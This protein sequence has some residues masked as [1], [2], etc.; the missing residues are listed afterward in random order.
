IDE[1]LEMAMLEAMNEAGA[2]ANTT[3]VPAVEVDA[4]PVELAQEDQA[5]ALDDHSDIRRSVNEI[6]QSLDR[7]LAVFD[8]HLLA[9]ELQTERVKSLLDQLDKMTER[10]Y[11]S[12]RLTTPFGGTFSSQAPHITTTLPMNINAHLN[13]A[14]SFRGMGAVGMLNFGG[15][16]QSTNTSSSASKGK[17]VVSTTYFDKALF[18]VVALNSPEEEG[19]IQPSSLGVS[20]GGLNKD[21]EF[22]VGNP[23]LLV[24]AGLGEASNASVIF[25][26]PGSSVLPTFNELDYESVMAGLFSSAPPSNSNSRVASAEGA[27]VYISWMLNLS[28]LNQ[29]AQCGRN[30]TAQR[31]SRKRRAPSAMEATIPTIPRAFPM[32][33]RPTMEMGLTKHQC[34]LAAYVFGENLDIK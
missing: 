11:H 12:N 10:S 3:D 31:A 21:P 13:A 5:P 23:K 27:V 19:H 33:F 18:D 2:N 8:A 29:G 9:L 26:F 32:V 20:A 28:T 1:Q 25:H 22:S 4:P 16:V 34:K 7:K 15:N 30:Q 24:N 6:I 14:P 17:D